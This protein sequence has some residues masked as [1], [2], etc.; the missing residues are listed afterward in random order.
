MDNVEEK[1]ES[2][3]FFDNSLSPHTFVILDKRSIED[4]TCII[5]HRFSSP[6]SG[7]EGQEWTSK[8]RIYEWQSWR[9]KFLVAWHTCTD[10]WFKDEYFLEML[11]E[12][13]YIYI[14]DHGVLQRPDVENNTSEFPDLEYR[15]PYGVPIE[16]LT[17]KG[18]TLVDKVEE[19]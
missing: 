4:D 10:L 7:C 11:P 17:L 16:G 15:Q 3:D 6:V 9:V 18:I 5:C 14:D 1:I 8:T 12:G 2:P 13:R 19:E